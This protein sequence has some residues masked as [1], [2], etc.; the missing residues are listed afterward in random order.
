MPRREDTLPY[1]QVSVEVVVPVYNEEKALPESISALCDYLTAYFPYQWSV[2]IA[3]NASSDTTPIVARELAA[4]YPRVS[5]L[6]L[7][8][9]GRGR[10]L[11]A[12]WSASGA[13]IVAYMDVDLSTNLWSFL[14]LVAPLATG[15]SDVAIGSRLLKGATV[16]RQWRRELISR[17]YNLLIKAL[18]R[19][20]FSDAQCG[21]KALKRSAALELLPHVED[22]EWFFDT[23]LLLLAEQRGYRISEVPVDWIEDLDTRVDVAS[24]ALEDV[25]GL[26]RVRVERLRCW[27]H[28]HQKTPSGQEE[29]VNRSRRRPFWRAWVSLCIAHSGIRLVK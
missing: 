17:C 28:E 26:L 29:L 1:G 16:T 11:K 10:A 27:L 9:K 22:D 19:N 5:V 20:R 15:H 6:R 8:E 7:E 2:V 23:E 12:A 21:F 18:F 4:R 14:P 13:D 25:K 24:T 3:D